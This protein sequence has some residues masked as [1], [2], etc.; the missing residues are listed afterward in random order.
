MIWQRI[1]ETL[2]FMERNTC[3]AFIGYAFS[4]WRSWDAP[5]KNRLKFGT[6]PF[7]LG[8]CGHWESYGLREREK[9]GT[10]IFFCANA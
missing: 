9:L 5:N 10:K 1:C 7:I 8:S 6:Y 2:D 3:S 4:G